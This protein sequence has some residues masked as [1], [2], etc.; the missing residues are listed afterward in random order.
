M[1]P[2]Y[3]KSGLHHK[4]AVLEQKQ[5]RGWIHDT[6][7]Q[8]IRDE[9]FQRLWS[10]EWKKLQTYRNVNCLRKWNWIEWLILVLYLFLPLQ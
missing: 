1:G 8:K 6:S 4:E 3:H 7:S 9:E 10:Q 2:E 5:T